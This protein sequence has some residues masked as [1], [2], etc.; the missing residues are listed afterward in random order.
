LAGVKQQAGIL[1]MLFREMKRGVR[2]GS[3]TQRGG[4][5]LG[6]E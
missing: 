1:P 6:F 3:E 4:G 5:R 2:R